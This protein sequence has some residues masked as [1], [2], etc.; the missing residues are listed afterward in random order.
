MLGQVVDAKDSGAKYLPI[1]TQIV[2]ATTDANNLKESLARYKDEESQNIVYRLFVQKAKPLLDKNE[3]DAD[4]G[5]KLLDI[6]AEIERD[7]SSTIQQVA[8][9][10]IKIALSAIQT[11]KI[12]GLKQVGIIDFENHPTLNIVGWD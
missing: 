12:Y 9:E 10:D 4:L 3:S 8:I 11:N 7:V 2:A 5:I 6:S 1:T